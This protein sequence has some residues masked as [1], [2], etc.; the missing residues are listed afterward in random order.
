MERTQAKKICQNQVQDEERKWMH[1]N[2]LKE[3]RRVEL[4]IAWLTHQSYKADV[5]TIF[6][7]YSGGHDINSVTSFTHCS[8]AYTP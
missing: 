1:E 3:N 7:A 4:L 8:S 2:N 5:S 6:I